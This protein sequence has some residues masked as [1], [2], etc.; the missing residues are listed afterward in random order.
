M[1]YKDREE[2]FLK[3]PRGR[4]K[5]LG[6]C[7]SCGSAEGRD[8]SRNKICSTGC[9][10][11]YK[12]ARLKNVTVVEDRCVHCNS[13]KYS[14]G[15]CL[16]NCTWNKHLIDGRLMSTREIANESGICF[17]H[18]QTFLKKYNSIEQFKQHQR[19]VRPDTFQQF[20]KTAGID[21]TTLRKARRQGLKSVRKDIQ[22]IIVDTQKRL[23][24]KLFEES[25]SL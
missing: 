2:K 12:Y 21:I 11:S 15:R 22:K 24:V 4:R 19:K 10:Y 1:I 18:V 14:N 6:Q 7:P 23:N 13:K 5:Q 25:E 20:A 9:G 16:K 17:K 3:V 8:I